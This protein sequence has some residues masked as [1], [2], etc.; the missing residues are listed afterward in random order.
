[1][2]KKVL[3]T[4][5]AVPGGL[6]LASVFVVPIVRGIM[7][8]EERRTMLI[9]AGVLALFVSMAVFGIWR[10]VRTEQKAV[11]QTSGVI[12]RARRRLSGDETDTDDG[13]W[14]RIRYCVDQQEYRTTKYVR[15]KSGVN[16]KNMST[17]T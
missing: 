7:N 6:I 16:A 14:F 8:E 3:K 2:M 5:F 1:M 15:F 10:R 17:D 11:A 12:I 13:W 9:V 4:V